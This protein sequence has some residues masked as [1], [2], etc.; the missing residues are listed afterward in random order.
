MT[1]SKTSRP[2]RKT[3]GLLTRDQ[4]L[5]VYF[6]AKQRQDIREVRARIGVRSDS[7]LV[8]GLIE[9]LLQNHFDSKGLDLALSRLR[10]DTGG[11]PLERDLT[12]PEPILAH[13]SANITQNKG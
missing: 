13:L 12:E 10:D 1:E 8:S 11:L 6:T 3:T 9:L 4:G 2:G 7:A 5:S